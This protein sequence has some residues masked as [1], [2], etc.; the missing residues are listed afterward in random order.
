MPDNLCE[1][2]SS[3]L[4]GRA[5]QRFCCNACRQG[6]YRQQRRARVIEQRGHAALESVGRTVGL[7]IP[8]WLRTYNERAAAS[9]NAGGPVSRNGGSDA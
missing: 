6:H 5:D 4:D 1:Q 2:C 7:P 8:T 9:R 3:L